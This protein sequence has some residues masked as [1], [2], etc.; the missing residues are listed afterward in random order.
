MNING[1]ICKLVSDKWE[2]LDS[3]RDMADTG[4]EYFVH[5]SFDNK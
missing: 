1:F 3:E 4:D 2:L 5:E